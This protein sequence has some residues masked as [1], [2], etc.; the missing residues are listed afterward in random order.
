[1]P[2]QPLRGAIFTMLALG[3]T[4]AGPPARA[5][6]PTAA[7]YTLSIAGLPIGSGELSVTPNGSATA[8]SL[9]GRV[10]GALEIGRIDANAT[11]SRAG[12]AAR[13]TSGSGKDA[14]E[15]NLA[16]NGNGSNRQFFYTGKTPR[17][18]GRIAMTVAGGNATAV[19]LDI[20]DATTARRVPVV[21]EH[22]RGIS[23]PLVVLAALVPPG[24]VLTPE[25]LCGRT[26]QVFTG[27]VRFDLAGGPASEVPAPRGAPEGWSATRCKVAYTPVSGHRIDKDVAGARPRTATLVFVTS[28]DKRRAALWSLSVSSSFGTFAMTA[29]AIR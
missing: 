10:G 22:K 5:S 24:G 13:T 6:E 25:G 9:K 16:S 3:A 28:P 12:V 15:A 27:Q 17:G 2:V 20:P 21:A 19:D 4:F 7:E 14:T 29:S 1:M 23:D 26:H 8:I 18:P 11:V